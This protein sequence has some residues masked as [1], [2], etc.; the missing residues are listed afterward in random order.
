M[1]FEA[2]RSANVWFLA[3]VAIWRV[4][5]LVRYINK[6]AGLSGVCVF[7]ATLLPLTLIVTVL[8]MLNLEHVVFNVMAG[9]EAHEQ[10]VNDSAYTVLFL[11]TTFSILVFPLLLALYGWF[12]YQR[13]TQGV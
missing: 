13:R 10:S 8:T 4:A 6:V 9:L 11:I 1:S 3:V 12:V 2:A 5:L 7:V